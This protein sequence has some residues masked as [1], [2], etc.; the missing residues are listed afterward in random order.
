MFKKF[1]PI[2]LL[3]LSISC[4]HAQNFAYVPNNNGTLDVINVSTNT[5]VAT[6]PG[7][8]H[9]FCATASPDGQLVYVCSQPDSVVVVNTATNSI[10][11]TISLPG[12]IGFIGN[13][14]AAPVVAFSPDGSLA[15]V[16]AGGGGVNSTLY[17][18]N[19]ASNTVVNSASFG[20][21]FLLAIAV[22][23][24]GNTVY[25]ATESGVIVVNANTLAT[26][27]SIAPGHI[28][29]DLAFSM[30][31]R[32]LYASDSSGLAGGQNGVLVI[33]TTSNTVTTAVPLPN[34][35]FVTGIGVT[36]DGQHVY[37]EEFTLTR[38]TNSTVFVID[39][40]VDAVV[41]TIP[42]NGDT[43]TALAITPDGSTVL[44][45]NSVLNTTVNSSVLVIPTATN[46]I[47]NSVTVGF[48]P[49]SIATTILGANIVKCPTVITQP[50]TYRLVN[51]LH[52]FNTNG[53]DIRSDNVTLMLDTPSRRTLLISVL[54]EGASTRVWGWPP[55]TRTC[56]FLVQEPL[57]VSIAVWIL[58][59]SQIPWSRM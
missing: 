40:S 25:L 48:F 43:L 52:C 33:A 16:F 36:P 41:D 1:L 26:I 53:I 13:E 49:I 12:A 8:D 2:I 22:P 47:A 32:T 11:A 31:G 6:I 37:V 27:T 30:D 42:A 56:R 7:F 4:L 18:I 5:V 54:P 39:A 9:P 59:R 46:T 35:S 19:T 14:G 20:T 28:L 51:D 57:P 17:V 21:T 45:V 58:S 23:A 50:G 3:V 29:F 38:P 55:E 44:A 10:S 15:Y 24:S 34:S